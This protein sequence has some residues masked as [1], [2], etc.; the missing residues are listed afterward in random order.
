MLPR[1]S[2]VKIKYFT[3]RISS[4]PGDPDQ[5]NRQ[6]VY[7]RA[8]RTIPNLEIIFGSF[9][10]TKPYMPLAA[11]PNKIVQVLKTEEKGSD[12]NI[13]THLVSDGYKGEY[14]VAALLTN[15]SDLAEAI[16]IVRKELTLTV[17]VLSPG[18]NTSQVLVRDASFVK[19]IRTATLK[20]SQ[21]STR[22]KDAK[23]SFTKPKQW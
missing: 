5:P 21:F 14:E 8:L 4:R 10:S 2:I 17:G 3:A 11:N 9:I 23:G 20:R 7:L 1:D 18:K 6:R 22:L 16:R 19:S 13:A 12:V 15:D